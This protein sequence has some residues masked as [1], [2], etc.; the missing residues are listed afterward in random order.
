MAKVCARLGHI[1]RVWHWNVQGEV[2]KGPTE[3]VMLTRRVLSGDTGQKNMRC[4]QELSAPKAWGTYR[5]QILDQV[6]GSSVD[7]KQW[8]MNLHRVQILGVPVGTP[9]CTHF[10][11]LIGGSCW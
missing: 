3:E 10:I 7:R 11:L 8:E 1:N 2:E 4:I 9:R 6:E 5:P